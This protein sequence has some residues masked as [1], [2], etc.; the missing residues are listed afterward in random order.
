MSEINV[1]PLSLGQFYSDVICT[2]TA[3]R[4]NLNVLS[5]TKDTV[6]AVKMWRKGWCMKTSTLEPAGLEPEI[7]CTADLSPIPQS[8]QLFM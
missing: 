6:M 5:E 7:F 4:R 3:G 1:V 2:V 8:P